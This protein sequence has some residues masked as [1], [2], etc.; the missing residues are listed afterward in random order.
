MHLLPGNEDRYAY[1]DDAAH[2]AAAKKLDEAVRLAEEMTRQQLRWCSE[3]GV[4]LDFGKA[5]A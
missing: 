2:A 4:E 3:N 5:E 1:A